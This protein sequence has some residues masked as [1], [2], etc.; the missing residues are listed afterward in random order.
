MVE[1]ARPAVC[2]CDGQAQG[3]RH[4]KIPIFSTER[5]DGQ[6]SEDVGA[7]NASVREWATG[8]DHGD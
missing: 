7:L 8:R 5:V 6:R 2:S 3:A 1:V 4:M